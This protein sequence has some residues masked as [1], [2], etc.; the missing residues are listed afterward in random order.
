MATKDLAS[1]LCRKLSVCCCLA[2]VVRLLA[3]LQVDFPLSVI[4]QSNSYAIHSIEQDGFGRSNWLGNSVDFEQQSVS[5]EVNGFIKGQKS[6]QGVYEKSQPG[7]ES[8]E[9]QPGEMS[10]SRS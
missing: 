7:L 3:N 10:G 6:G 8:G 4:W 1:R 2:T 9:E 5:N